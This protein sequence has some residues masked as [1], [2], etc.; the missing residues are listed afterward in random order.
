MLLPKVRS[1][2]FA[3][4]AELIPSGAVWGSVTS[5]GALWHVGRRRL[6]SNHQPCDLWMTHSTHPPP[7]PQFKELYVKTDWLSLK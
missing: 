5:P 7:D 2:V 1:K 4:F 3:K 6:E